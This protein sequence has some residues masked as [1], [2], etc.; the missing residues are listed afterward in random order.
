M[1]ACAPGPI[2]R[3]PAAQVHLAKLN[4]QQVV[5]KVQRPGLKELFDIDLKN[6]RALAVWLQKVSGGQGRALHARCSLHLR[7][8][9]CLVIPCEERG[10]WRHCWLCAASWRARAQSGG[11]PAVQHQAQYVHNIPPVS[12]HCCTCR[13]SGP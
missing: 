5:V 13:T 9:A 7:P 12:V 3:C 11:T 4:G 2:A 10:K 1:Q 6:I 8:H